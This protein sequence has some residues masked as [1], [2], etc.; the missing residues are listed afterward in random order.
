MSL[1]LLKTHENSKV[2]PLAMPGVPQSFTGSMLASPQFNTRMRDGTIS[3]R[4]PAIRYQGV[5][6]LVYKPIE[7]SLSG[8]QCSL[9]LSLCLPCQ[10]NIIKLW[11]I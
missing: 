8:R 9:F 5:Q 4:N 10:A 11:L 6:V 2:A 3:P 7:E 1:D